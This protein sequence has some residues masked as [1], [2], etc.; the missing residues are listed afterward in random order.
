[1]SPDTGEIRSPHFGL[2]FSE[3]LRFTLEMTTL[4][5]TL[6]MLATVPRG[7][8]HPV[9]VLP[10][11]AT[12]DYMTVLLRAFLMQ[13]GY[14]V[15]PL[16]LGWNFDHHTVG[17]NGEHMARRIA[18]IRAQSGRKVSLVGWSLGGV[19]A[20]EAARRDPQDIRQVIALGSPFTGDPHATNLST[21]YQAVTGNDFT[22]E[23]AKARYAEGSDPLPVPSSAIYSRFDGV[24]AWRNCLGQTDAINENIEIVSSH[25]GFVANPA[26]FYV[27]AD[28]LAQPQG[29]WKRFVA[30]GPFRS[31]FA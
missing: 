4:M 14:D 16:D 19:I 7:D 26:V 8:G 13:W 12:N 25:F 11:F 3:P 28:R 27:I 23:R 30:S 31:F 1:M 6:P 18:E 5:M 24:T 2:A 22:S 20:R 21:V 15:H 10:G 9:M 17:E 29:G